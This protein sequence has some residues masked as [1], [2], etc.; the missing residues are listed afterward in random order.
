MFLFARLDYQGENFES[1]GSTV[2]P[3]AAWLSA[4]TPA[5][6]KVRSPGWI[7]TNL[8]PAPSGA[9]ESVPSRIQSQQLGMGMQWH[10]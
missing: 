4:S 10:T 8:G 5:D 3:F 2:L 1:W 6:L 7:E 9:R